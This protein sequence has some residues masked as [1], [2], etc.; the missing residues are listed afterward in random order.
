MPSSARSRPAWNGTARQASTRS[1]AGTKR[2][3]S[4]ASLRIAIALPVVKAVA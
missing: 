1:T 2:S 3:S 4:S